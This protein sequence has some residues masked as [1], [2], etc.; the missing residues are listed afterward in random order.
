VSQYGYVLQFSGS[1]VWFEAHTGRGVRTLKLFTNAIFLDVTFV[2]YIQLVN[3]RC[4][5]A[6]FTGVLK[7]FRTSAKIQDME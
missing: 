2:P 6:P 5:D 4:T 1:T 3:Y 7:N